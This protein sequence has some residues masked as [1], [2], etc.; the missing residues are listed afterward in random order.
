MDE[1]KEYSHGYHP[2]FQEA[3]PYVSNEVGMEGLP[4]HLRNV[5][6]LEET[7]APVPEGTHDCILGMDF[8][9]KIRP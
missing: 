8:Q 1:V 9:W 5:L 7:A 3:C 4:D 6:I 2:E